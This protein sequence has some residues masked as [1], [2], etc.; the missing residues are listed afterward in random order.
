MKTK[1]DA[2]D[3]NLIMLAKEYS[4][5][6]KARKLFESL[7][8]PNGKPICPF[9]KFDESYKIVSKHDSKNKRRA[10]L[11][12][13]AACRKTYTA[14]V[15]TVFEDTRLPLSKWLMATFILCS[16]KKSVSAMQLSRMLKVTYKTAWFMAHRLRF[17]MGTDLKTAKPLENVCEADETFVGTH[18]DAKSKFN[19]KTTV[20]LVLE[21]DGQSRAQ[22]IPS[23]TA[24][25]VGRFLN[26]RVSRKATVNTDEHAAYKMP[27]K[28]FA[29]HDCVNH[30][31]YEYARHNPD[32]TVS[33][34]NSCESWFSLLKRSVFGAWHC[35]SREHLPKYVNEI[36]FRWN[37]RKVTD[38]ERMAAFMP[39][40]DGK[41]LMYRQ[42]AN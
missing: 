42:P 14:T 1:L 7:R 40:I 27:M 6:R 33:H 12:C 24:R 17:A 20:A 23:V 32:G 16:S 18:E 41:R 3:L 19:V 21:R 37:T 9:C 28:D 13:C 30:G 38:G 35:V 15:G 25:N 22:I 11:Y 10:G 34:V 8:W 29:R 31:K 39:M 5:E 2:E 4:S 36:E 26:E